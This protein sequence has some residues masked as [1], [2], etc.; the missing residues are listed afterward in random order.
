MGP[1]RSAPARTPRAV[2]PARV[3]IWYSEALRLV[4]RAP[5]RFVLL[6]AAMLVTELVLSIIPLVGPP[7]ANM[8][9]PLVA[10]GLLYASLAADR[11]EPI[12]LRFAV[13]A[14]AANAR[15]VAAVILASIVA[16][17]AEAAAAAWLAGVNLLAPESAT[18]LSPGAL[19][20]VFAAG[21]VTSLPLTFVPFAALFDGEGVRG[22]FAASLSAFA[23]NPLT[24][25]LYAAASFLLVLV[26]VMTYGVGLLLALP[27]WATS[28]YAAWK[29]VFGVAGQGL[30]ERDR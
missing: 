23:R 1:T 8:V 28:S 7:L 30:P 14:F 13:L 11:G 6:A 24:L 4:K 9:V 17:A 21:I 27:L 20:A 15:A 5:G 22:S 25:L 18:T 26:G 19:V 12:R 10:C 3:A 29:D 16:F 2:A